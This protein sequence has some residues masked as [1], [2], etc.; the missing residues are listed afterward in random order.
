MFKNVNPD[1]GPGRFLL[2]WKL[3]KHSTTT[4]AVM[5]FYENMMQ[6]HSSKVQW[7]IEIQ[8]SGSQMTW[9]GWLKEGKQPVT[10]MQLH[11]NAEII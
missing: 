7:G 3:K 9:E 11:E 6:I 2:I 1:S 4:A 10:A 8:C 5:S